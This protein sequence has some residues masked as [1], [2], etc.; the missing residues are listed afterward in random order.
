MFCCANCFGDDFLT[1]II[2]RESSNTGICDFCKMENTDLI[3]PE[4][5]NDYFQPLIDL[6]DKSEEGVRVSSLLK[7][8]WMLFPSLNEEVIQE[9]LH[10]IFQLPINDNYIPKKDKDEV[11]ILNWQEFKS[12]LKHDNRYFPKK[13]PSYEHLQALLNFI[14]APIESIPQYLYRARINIDTEIYPI[15]EMGKP[16]VKVSTAGRANPLGIPYLYTASNLNTA[17][18]EIRPHK[19][20]NVSVAKFEVTEPLILADLRNP[21]KTISPFE[22]DE[23]GLNQVYLDLNYLCHLGEE[24]SKPILPRDAQLEYLSTQYLCELIKHCGFDGVIYKSSVGD[25]D[26]YAIFTDSKLQSAEVEVYFVND[27]EITSNR[28]V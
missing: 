13:A 20:D 9:L 25:G 7:I 2:V 10:A 27:I 12:E 1:T 23:N 19:G 21:R 28:I 8:D 16:P 5:L 4:L 22:L 6:Y 14:I 3:S 11:K 17:I 26:N 24:L 18:A 15:S